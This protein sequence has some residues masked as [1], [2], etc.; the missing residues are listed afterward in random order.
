MTI[1]ESINDAE[2]TAW[3]GLIGGFCVATVK[4][5]R[6]LHNFSEEHSLLMEHLKEMT[7]LIPKIIRTEEL[8]RVAQEERKEMLEEVRGLRRD[9]TELYAALIANNGHGRG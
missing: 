2:K 5:V 8:V 6:W 3:L 4:V 9:L 7:P 1:Y